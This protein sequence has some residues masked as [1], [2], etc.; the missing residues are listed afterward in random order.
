M[1]VINIRSV[2]LLSL[3]ILLVGCATAPPPIEATSGILTSAVCSNNIDYGTTFEKG[4]CIK[5]NGEGLGGSSKKT[6]EQF[7]YHWQPCS[8]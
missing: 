7:G 5:P 8:D 1:M 4:N 6:C 2:V 3:P